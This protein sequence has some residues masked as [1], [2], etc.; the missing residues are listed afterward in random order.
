MATPNLDRQA[1][2]LAEL[3]QYQSESVVSRTLLKNESGNVTLFAFDAGETLSEHTTPHEAL[4]LALDG[5][6]Q[7]TVSGEPRRLNRGDVTVMPAN[8]PHAVRANSRC[9][10]LLV[11]MHD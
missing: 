6:L 11:M 5:E 7:I 3:V 9:K 10:M 2:P 1:R 8:Q 4:V